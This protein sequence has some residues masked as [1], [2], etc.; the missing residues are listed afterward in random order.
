MKITTFDKMLDRYGGDLAD[1]PACDAAQARK[2]MAI[3]APA[4]RSFAAAQMLEAHILDSRTVVDPMQAARVAARALSAV[5][6]RE[7]SPPLIDRLRAA[8][9]A[10]LPRAAFAVSL[11]AIGF[12]IGLAVGAPMAGSAAEP[13]AS[14]LMMASAADGLY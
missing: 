3:S 1:W 2:L 9:A 13:P 8:L 12:S 5:A 4:R 7:A 11:T 14:T 10:P 6:A